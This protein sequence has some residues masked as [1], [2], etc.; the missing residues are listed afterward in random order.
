M[1]G[2]LVFNHH[3]LPFDHHSLADAAIPDFLKVCIEAKNAGLSTILIDE[4]VDKN[5]F[6]Q[7]LSSGY[8]FQDWYN[9]FKDGDSRDLLRA[10][11]TIATQQPFFNATDIENEAELF[12]VYLFGSSYIALTAAAW[13]IAPILS[14]ETRD[15]WR[16]ALLTVDVEQI[17]LNTKDLVS[18]QVEIQNWFNYPVFSKSVATILAMRDV[19]LSSGRAVVA[20]AEMLYPFVVLCGKSKQ[21]LSKWSASETIFE[22]IKKSLF[23][24]NAFCEKWQSGQFDYYSAD[25]LKESGLPFRVNGE[26]ET[27]RN[28]PALKRERMFWLPSGILRFFEDHIKLAYGYRLHFYPDQ[29]EK[30]IYVGYI[31][32]HLKLN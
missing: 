22:Q 14:F 20:Q 17:D 12:D 16:T 26:S 15:P 4:L 3:S 25:N 28:N 18:E 19:L 23:G 7:E 24:L 21:Q 27:V 32:T 29:T 31:G 2:T 10:F 8:F 6:R 11:R 9:K 1:S 5:W 13:H 30:K